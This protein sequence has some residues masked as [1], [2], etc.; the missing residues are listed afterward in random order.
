MN[1]VHQRLVLLGEGDVLGLVIDTA[2][3]NHRNTSS[4]NIHC[5]SLVGIVGG[6]D[7]GKHPPLVAIKASKKDFKGM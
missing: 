3:N 5:N 6:G 1:T 2:C 4:W 7:V